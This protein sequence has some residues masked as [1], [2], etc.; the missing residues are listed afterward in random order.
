MGLRMEHTTFYRKYVAIHEQKLGIF[1]DFHPK[2]HEMG[3]SICE[4]FVIK[5]IQFCWT[6]ECLLFKKKIVL[7]WR[8][9]IAVFWF[10]DK[11]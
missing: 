7:Y 6:F 3:D 4:H 8:V 11:N 9:A 10:W 5:E 2:W 1:Q